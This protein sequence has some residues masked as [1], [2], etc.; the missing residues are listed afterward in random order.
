MIGSTGKVLLCIGLAVAGLGLAM[1]LADRPGF[2]R[3]LPERIPLGR[4]PG[5]LRWRGE[6]FS[7]YFPWVTCLVVSVV[8]TLLCSFFRK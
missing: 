5:D 8:V 4:L 1:I 3:S 6:G 7:V 2:W